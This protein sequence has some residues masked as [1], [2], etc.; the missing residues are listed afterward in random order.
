MTASAASA[1]EPPA[2]VL[3][4]VWKHHAGALRGR[5]REAIAAGPAGLDALASQLTVVG[6]D[7]MDLYLGDLSPGRIGELLLGRLRA[8]GHFELPAYRDW[9]AEGGG[10][11]VLDLDEDG[12]RWVLRL[13]DAADRYVHVHPARWAPLTCRVRANLLKTAVMALAY[14]GVH[15]GDPMDRALV[16]DVRRRYLGLAPIGRE[17]PG[18]QGWGT[19]VGRLRS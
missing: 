7:L 18:G 15:G 14:A 9:I 6:A 11:R 10:Y 8:A 5:I 3:L 16:N 4:N 12:S 13:G 2:P 17:L 1:W 19:L